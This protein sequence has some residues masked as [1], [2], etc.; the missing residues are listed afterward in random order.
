[1]GRAAGAR[2]AVGHRRL[3]TRTRQAAAL[4]ADTRAVSLEAAPTTASQRRW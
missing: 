4:G 2:Q 3:A 1:M